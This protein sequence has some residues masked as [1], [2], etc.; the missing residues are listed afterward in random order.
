LEPLS[1]DLER[2]E[3]AYLTTTGRVTGRPHRI[4]IWFAV[5]GASVWL[6][7]GG[8]DRSD[9]VRNLKADPH[10]T[11]EIGNH[12]WSAVA[13]AHPGLEDH[14]ARRRLASRYQG[15]RPGKDLSTWAT[16]GLLVEVSPR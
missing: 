4:E 11:L 5:V 13:T 16:G 2:H 3:Y 12:P 15:W 8:R 1:I 14:P 7:S 9:W 6:N 10:V